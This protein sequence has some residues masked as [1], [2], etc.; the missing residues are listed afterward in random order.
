MSASLEFPS[1]FTSSQN[2]YSFF[3]DFRNINVDSISHDPKMFVSERN[4]NQHN[5]T[6]R[7]SQSFVWKIISVSITLYFSYGF[8]FYLDYS[9]VHNYFQQFRC[10]GTQLQY[11]IENKA[12]SFCLS[13]LIANT[14]IRSN[15]ERWVVCTLHNESHTHTNTQFNIM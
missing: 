8:Q 13:S 6:L 9:N 3:P 2:Q 15:G 1:I 11:S 10:S 14:G 5:I 12:S 4:P 7:K